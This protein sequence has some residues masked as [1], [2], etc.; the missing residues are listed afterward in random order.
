MSVI[1]WVSIIGLIVSVFA[2]AWTLFENFARPRRRY[3]WAVAIA[4]ATSAAAISAAL[5]EKQTQYSRLTTVEHEIYELISKKI[6]EPD[7]KYFWTLDDL[8]EVEQH[9]HQNWQN[10]MISLV[11]DSLINL[12]ESDRILG[13]PYSWP[14]GSPRELHLATV[15]CIDCRP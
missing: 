10:A 3:L 9:R 7:A 11:Q 1:D 8:I 5:I 6:T 4:L 2:T 12:R 15:Y 13:T 14:H